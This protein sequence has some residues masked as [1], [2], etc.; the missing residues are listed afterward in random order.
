MSFRRFSGVKDR[1]RTFD[2][3][4]SR[5]TLIQKYESQFVARSKVDESKHRYLMGHGVV[6]SGVE[7]SGAWQNFIIIIY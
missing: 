4:T 3:G 1:E 6:D 7:D 5:R 2:P